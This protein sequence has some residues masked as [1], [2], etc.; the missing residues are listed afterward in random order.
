MTTVPPFSFAVCISLSPW[1]VLSP[2]VFWIQGEEVRIFL[3]I[4][5]LTEPKV[6]SQSTSRNKF[7]CINVIELVFSVRVA[8]V[9][10]RPTAV[11]LLPS[12]VRWTSIHFKGNKRESSERTLKQ[13]AAQKNLSLY[14]TNFQEQCNRMLDGLN[15]CKLQKEI[16][17]H[18]KF[19]L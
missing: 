6:P 11:S 16:K 14:A 7:C 3:Q 8:A 15:F 10:T 9:V 17:I 12:K 18:C 5:S 13:T 19:W 4:R 1:A 2:I